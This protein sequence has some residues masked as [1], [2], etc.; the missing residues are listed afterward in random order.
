MFDTHRIHTRIEEIRNRLRILNRDFKPLTEE[1]IIADENLYAAAERHL[2][3]AIQCCIDISTHIIAR[4]GL[5]RPKESNTEVFVILSQ[6][7]IIPGEF[8]EKLAAM[9]G[10]RNILTHEYLS[11]QRHKT[12][13]NIQNNLDDFAQ[14][15]RYIESFLQKGG[16]K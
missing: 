14:F 10:F 7:K 4:L 9:A 15:A 8:A 13:L 16:S 1:K 3:V 11:I 6:E 2:E 5:P 12:Y